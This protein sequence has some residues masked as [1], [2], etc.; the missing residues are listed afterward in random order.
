MRACNF[1]ARGSD[2]TKLFHVTCREA[3]MTTWE[4]L[5]GDR[6]HKIWE[7][8][9]RLKLGAI[10]DNLRFRSP[11]SPER[12]EISQIGNTTS[13]FVCAEFMYTTSCRLL[14]TLNFL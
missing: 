2:L 10:S 7:G 3:G 6:T 14:W 1:A 8:R 5:F 11:M 4:Q 9:K 12:I 13:V